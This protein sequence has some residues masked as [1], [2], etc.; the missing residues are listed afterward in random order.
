MEPGCEVSFDLV[1]AFACSEFGGSLLVQWVASVPG[2]VHK[3][4]REGR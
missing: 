1:V 2:F 4:H 3:H